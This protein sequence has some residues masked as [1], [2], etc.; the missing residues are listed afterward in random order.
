MVLETIFGIRITFLLGITNLIGLFLVFFS[1]RCLIGHKIAN[2]LYQKEWYRK[3]YNNHCYY[4]WFFFASVL[5]H[6]IFAFL[7]FGNP[8]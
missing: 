8:F 2:K 4:W 6:T 5:L 3:F 7:V 1:C